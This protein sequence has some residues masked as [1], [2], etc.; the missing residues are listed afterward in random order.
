MKLLGGGWPWTSVR[1][2]FDK[3]KDDGELSLV[4][5]IYYILEEVRFYSTTKNYLTIGQ[6][7]KNYKVYVIDVKAQN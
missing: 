2:T 7:V 1:S 5:W 3:Q 4:C 6:L